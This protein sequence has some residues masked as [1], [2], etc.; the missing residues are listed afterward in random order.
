M[1]Q[2][3]QKSSAQ[4]DKEVIQELKVNSDV[5]AGGFLKQISPEVLLVICFLVIGIILRI[6]Q[7]VA[8]RSLW[9]DEAML[10]LN[11]THRSFAGLT[12]PLDYNQAAP[13][14]F[15]FVQKDIS[16]VLGN[17][18][19]ALR[20]FPLMAGLLSLFL[21]YKTAKKYLQGTAGYIALALFCFSSTLIYYSSENKQYSSDVLFVLILLLAAHPCFQDS[22]QPKSFLQLAAI[23]I[24]AMW[25]SHPAVFVLAAIGIVVIILPAFNKAWAKLLWP[26]LTCLLWL[27]NLSFLYIISLRQTAANK[28]VTSYWNDSFMPMPPWNNWGWFGNTLKS[29]FQDP[30]GLYFVAVSA[31]LLLV[32]CISIFLRKWALGIV[33]ILTIMTTL[34]A[35]G[36]QKY[37]FSGRLI[38]FLVPTI[39]F[40]IAEG[41]ERIRGTLANYS[42]LVASFTVAALAL[43]LLAQP[44]VRALGGLKNPDMREHIR[45]I[46]EYVSQNKRSTDIL[47]L[48]YGAKPAF[49]YY[50]PFY[51]FKDS[52][53]RVGVYARSEPEKYLRDIDTLR[54]NARVW[55]VFSHNYNWGKID[56]KMHYLTHLNKI[57]KKIDEFSAPSA[58]V[59]LYDL[60]GGNVRLRGVI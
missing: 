15:L 12:Q 31:I 53:F 8:N 32:G 3:V 16:V 4:I 45:P 13:L 56:E 10:A 17:S 27:A 43:L 20:L 25:M 6:W 41:I 59:Y 7:Y 37:P 28:L 24:I 40:L 33:L 21:M 36:F 1:E 51:G 55:F 22:A 18:E 34:I 19:F 52:D 48:Y 29:S 23:G 60:K 9:L 54:G 57:G 49:L 35:S 42:R 5:N 2:V 44:A 38:L 30:W 11:I 50:A 39:F 47:Y 14:L 58:V 46:V 26:M